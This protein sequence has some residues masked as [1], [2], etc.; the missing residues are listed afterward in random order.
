MFLLELGDKAAW[1][2][3]SYIKK[4]ESFWNFMDNVDRIDESKVSTEEFIEK[5]EKPY[6][7][8]IIQGVQNDWKAQSKWTI[9]VHVKHD[10]T[11]KHYIDIYG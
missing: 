9:E 10:K 5:Y 7:P 3:H 1:I 6:K 11:T 8:V 2:Q 4:F